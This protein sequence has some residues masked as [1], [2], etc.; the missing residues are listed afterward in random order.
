MNCCNPEVKDNG[1]WGIFNAILGWQNSAT[2]GSVVSYCMY[3]I[4]VTFALIVM[5]IDENRVARGE[6]TLLRQML[7]KGPKPI[8]HHNHGPISEGSS[9]D[10]V[11]TSM[12][13]DIA[14]AAERDIQSLTV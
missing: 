11:D 4:F 12:K 6:A 9:E 2:V 1:G 7:G 8:I 14:P 13:K 3:W 10:G 5:R